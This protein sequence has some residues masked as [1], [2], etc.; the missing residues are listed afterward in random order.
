MKLD[1][2]H[3]INFE[4]CSEFRVQSSEFR[5]IKDHNID[6]KNKNTRINSFVVFKGGQ[7]C[8]KQKNYPDRM[9]LFR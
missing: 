9:D 7:I 2:L 4:G 8:V 3:I 5:V 1:N 6:V